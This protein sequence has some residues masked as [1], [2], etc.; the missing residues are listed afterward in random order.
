MTEAQEAL[1]SLK[2]E[3][4]R[5]GSYI[6]LSQ[7][8]DFKVFTAEVEKRKQGLRDLLEIAPNEDLPEI[9]GQLKALRGMMDLFQATIER[10][11][12]LSERIK[13]I[14]DAKI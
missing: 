2:R 9:R 1:E 8:P 6:R 11:K 3:R 5:I 13:E 4:E 12:E 7:N 14:E 10:E